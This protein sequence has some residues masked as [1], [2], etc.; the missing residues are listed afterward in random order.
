MRL[1]STLESIFMLSIELFTVSTGCTLS[2]VAKTGAGFTEV[3]A[4]TLVVRETGQYW[5]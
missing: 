5:G 2:I 3:P 1:I 4:R